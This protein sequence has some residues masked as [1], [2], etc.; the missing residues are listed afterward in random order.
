M[1]A[2]ISNPHSQSDCA[3]NDAAILGM[4]M[5]GQGRSALDELTAWLNMVPPLT[6]PAWTEHNKNLAVKAAEACRDCR[7][8]ASK[9]LH[10]KMNERIDKSLM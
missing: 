5:S 7:I 4:R 3:I 10:V 2:N 9:Q 6:G 8:E 1:S